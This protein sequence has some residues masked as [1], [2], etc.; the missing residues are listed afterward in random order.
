MF[1]PSFVFTFIFFLFIFLAVES[2]TLGNETD[3]LA[4]LAFKNEIIDDPNGA[5]TSW[6]HTL[7]FCQWQGVTCSLRH[8]LRVT[9]LNLTN[10]G[11][12]GPTSPYIANLSFL[13][14]ID[15]SNNNFNGQIPS[16]ISHL[17]RLSW[18]DLST[19][20]YQ[21]VIPV[22][23]TIHCSK[24][25]Y[26]DLTYNE[27]VGGV[28]DKFHT[29]SRIA[30]LQ[31]SENNLTGTIPSSLGNLSSLVYLYLAGN[32]LEGSIPNELGRLVSLQE[33][34]L[35]TNKL[36]GMIPHSLYNIS[37]MVLFVVAGNLLYGSLPQDLG[38]T[39]P[40][41]EQ[42]LVG[43]NQFTGPIPVSLAN[44]SGLTLIDFGNNNFSGSLPMN[45]GSL[46]DLNILSFESNQLGSKGKSND[47]IFLTS[48]T[49]CSSLQQ[50]LLDINYISG[51][52]PN[53]IANLSSQLINLRLGRNQIFGSIPL[54][55][56]NLVNL[57]A[58]GMEENSLTGI[59]P[60]GIGKLSKL[61]ALILSHNN[62]FGQIPPSIGNISQLSQLILSGN[63]L[64]GSIPSSFGKCKHMEDLI[65][66]KNNLSGTIPIEILQLSS[67]SKSLDF[68][69][70]SF[71]GSLA[72]EVGNMNQLGTLV[73]SY[74]RVSGEI[75]STL[76][77]CLSLEYLYMDHNSLQGIIPSSLSTLKAI[78][79]LDLSNNNLS[80]NIPKYL[81]K[82]PFLEYLNLSFNDLEGEVP[83]AGIFRN[84]SA[85]S[86]QGNNKLCGGIFELQLPACSVQVYKKHRR[87]H[88][89]RV[90]LSITSLILCLIL[91]SC[92]FAIFYWVRKSKKKPF[93]TISL[94]NQCLQVSYAELLRATNGFSLDN[95]IG[96]G[97]YGSVYKG[98]LDQ[99]QTAIAVK[100][101]NLQQRGAYESFDAECEALRNIRHRNLVKIL[102][103]CSSIDFHGNDFKALVFEYMPN[104]NLENWLHQSGDEEHPMRNLTLIQRLNIAIDVASALD[105]LHH[106]G[107]TPI[108]HRD[109]KPS[110]ILLD[111]DMIAHLGDFGLAKFLFKAN[112]S[113]SE[114]QT[115]SM[116]IK[117]SIGY[118][119]PEH[120]IGGKASTR[121]DVYSYG[122]LLLE[123]FTGKRPTDIIFTD[124][125]SLYQFA[126]MALPG[127]V[128]EIADQQLLSEVE[129]TKNNNEI[130]SNMK[131]RIHDCLLS[132]FRIGVTCC[133]ESPRERMEMG[134]VVIQLHVI[135]DIYL[136]I[137]V[138]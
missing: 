10:Q 26:I 64:Q 68:S 134:D 136:G 39:L 29:F 111:D 13:S 128:M 130:H 4:L 81:E 51:V 107:Q 119:A 24:L 94:E 58:L 82:F 41:L 67:P 16:D 76:G 32:I 92:F 61:R 18:L 97:S 20:S 11:L 62:F 103:S 79:E 133:V 37:S 65:L 106:H 78:R 19:N 53:S 98:I 84:A 75:P 91:F 101:L 52:L 47:L 123:I 34:S 129:T 88:S 127:R 2:A 42:L 77:N 112:D 9:I 6:N 3:R 46:Q 87:S 55:I 116:G 115:N 69:H 125:L 44:A 118:I 72:S 63:N 105:Y 17:F 70:N 50:L 113:R 137:R 122:I 114:N 126:K 12:V 86:V 71:T 27:L 56:E 83:K 109:L 57:T 8:P 74:N 31:I 33:L 28:P 48:L 30:F 102:T 22:N 95:L 85:I 36:S 93:N 5:L 80:G 1:G 121:G 100:V 21:G 131:N 66:S 7:H 120:G 23:I 138:Y 89:L 59:I 73:I 35:Y 132:V 135:K 54:G 99:N 43:G 15:L 108:I 96:V 25:L 38:L 110:N 90:I 60:T 45:L 40:N 117:G 104:G 14:R 124:G 49:N